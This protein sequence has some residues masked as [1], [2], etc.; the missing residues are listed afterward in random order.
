MIAYL[1]EQYGGAFPLWLAPVQVLVL[2]IAD[3][4]HEYARQVK[5]K[6]LAAGFRVEVDARNEKLRLQDP[7]GAEPEVPVHAGRWVTKTWRRA[8]SRCA[9]GRRAT[10]ARSRWTRSSRRRGPS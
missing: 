6:L 2:P 8:P 10:R 3:R 1:I 5:E 9:R 4:H 7:R